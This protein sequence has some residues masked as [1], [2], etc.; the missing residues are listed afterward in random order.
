MRIAIVSDIRGNRTA[1]KAVLADLHQTSPDLIYHGGDLAANGAHPAE[2]VDTIQDLHWPG[3][4]GNT[5]EILWAPGATSSLALEV[6][7]LQSLL[8]TLQEIV[9]TTREWLGEDRLN[10]LRRLPDIQRQDP[11]AII[12]ASPKDL[13]RAPMP[14][15]TDAELRAVYGGLGVPIVVYAHIHR[16]YIRRLPEMCVANTGSM[17]LSYDGD[18]RA[19]YLV[20][21]DHDVS[22]RRVDYDIER[23]GDEL[24]SSGVP[25]ADWLHHVLRT[26]KYCHPPSPPG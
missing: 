16:P 1:L 5:D 20:I 13:W 17:S 25:H 8:R 21:D 23:E 22:I 15:A 3:V 11:F 18:T 14:T 6:P 9:P 19:S 2:V 4:C 24:R 12:H 10:W 26:G 7:K